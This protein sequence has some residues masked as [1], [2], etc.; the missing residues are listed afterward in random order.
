MMLCITQMDAFYALN[1]E[2][3]TFVITNGALKGTY[4]GPDINYYYT[5]MVAA[6]HGISKTYMNS[7]ITAYNG[8]QAIGRW[9]MRDINQ[10]SVGKKFADFGYNLYKKQ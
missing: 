6:H 5:G 8:A 9:N 10:I 1:N 7:L 3:Q 2:H 4:S